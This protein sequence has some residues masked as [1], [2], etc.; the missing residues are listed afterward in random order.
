M[1]EKFFPKAVINGN[2]LQFNLEAVETMNLDSPDAKLVILE[3]TNPKR[4]KKNKEILIVK[5]NGSLFDDPEV[6][7]DTI[8]VS[9]IRNV[10]VEKEDDDNIGANVT[11]LDPSITSIHEIFGEVNEFKLL[12]CNNDSALGKEFREVFDIKDPYY[13]LAEVTDKRDSI[14]K[15]KAINKD[16][17]EERVSL[18][19]SN[20]N[21]SINAKLSDFDVD[22]GELTLPKSTR[23]R[24]RVSSI[25]V[26]DE[27]EDV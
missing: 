17:V 26:H 14:G 7:K 19:G 22:F 8:D 25:E 3:V 24:T 20:T 13:R 4:V 9:L 16:V 27:E 1:N 23:L 18:D 11:M 2:M 6:L 12:T 5:T 21:P 15:E 10:T